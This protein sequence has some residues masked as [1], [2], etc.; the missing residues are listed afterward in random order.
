MGFVPGFD[1][2]VFISHAHGDDREWVDR[3]VVRLQTALSRL[4]PGAAVWLET[5]DQ[6]KSRNFEADI[7][8]ALESSAVLISL[9]SPIYITRPYCVQHECRRFSEVVAARKQ[10]DPRFA[11][12]E[13][14]A[15]LFGFRCPILPMPDNAYWAEL[16]PGA[17]DV[18]FHD[19]LE[20]YPVGAPLFEERFRQLLRELVSLLRRMRHRSTAVFVYPRRPVAELNEAHS[21]LTRELTAQSYRILP[22]DELDP[23]P[24]L[25]DCNLAVLLL[26]AAYDPNARRLADAA[27][28]LDKQFLIWPS[29]TIANTGAL[30]QRGFLDYLRQME[31]P[32]K[33]LLDPAIPPEKLKQDVFAL[34]N[35]QAKLPA[36]AGGKPRVYLIYDVRANT[37]KNHAGKIAFHYQD[38][39]H[40]EHSD[41][42]RQHN[43]CLRQ[44]DGILLVWGEADEAWCAS[45]FEQMV[46]LSWQPKSRGLCL[47]DPQ[48]SKLALA[49]QIRVQYAGLHV[50]EEFGPFDPAR[51]EPFFAPL[52]RS[53]AGA[54]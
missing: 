14:A 46:R 12:P 16:I 11:S 19:D 36:C 28:D 44:S 35:S 15:E 51:L 25:A 20:T 29:P 5:N 32:R 24:R 9:V 6:R 53:R 52:R 49:G 54:A 45:E 2:D 23:A 40:F 27:R 17:T 31:S 22:E 42:P 30:E 34:L 4:L 39:F 3:F 26:G 10:T 8:A 37:E 43:V 13:F 50:A 41:K 48:E 21:A 18:S 33:S 38:E 7:P 47:F 1:S